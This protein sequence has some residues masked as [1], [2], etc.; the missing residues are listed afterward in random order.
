M[1]ISGGRNGPVSPLAYSNISSVVV[2]PA[3]MIY[4]A[5]I[6][7]KG[8]KGLKF[9][10]NRWNFLLLTSLI[11]LFF[12]CIGGT[13][14][15]FTY[16]SSIK[17]QFSIGYNEITIK[18][19]YNPPDEIKVGETVFKKN[20]KVKNTGN[21]PCYIRIFCEF[22][23][24]DM[25]K[26]AELTQDGITWFN[27][28]KLKDNLMEGWVFVRDDSILG[29]YYYYTNAV[30]KNRETPQLFDKVRITIPDNQGDNIKDFDIIT[31]AESIQIKDYYAN[32]YSGN[33]GWENAWKSFLTDIDGGSE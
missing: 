16:K 18:E 19:N 10:R 15:Y 2:F 25:K 29:G 4:R 22:S 11:F 21:I 33:D 30:E 27:A 28:D 26:Y 20:I 7:L 17:N 13:Y 6:K 14:A 9:I 23:E 32:E 12:I 5:Q 24:S 8:G 3:M 31:Y 1:N